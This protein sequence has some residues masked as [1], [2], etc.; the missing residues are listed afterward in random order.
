MMSMKNLKTDMD[1]TYLYI[2]D[3]DI[4]SKKL[5]QQIYSILSI[6]G[7]EADLK[8]LMDAFSTA[9]DNLNVDTSESIASWISNDDNLGKFMDC[10]TIKNSLPKLSLSCLVSNHS[11]AMMIGYVNAISDNLNINDPDIARIIESIYPDFTK[12]CMPLLLKNKEIDV[13]EE[14]FLN[15]KN[16]LYN[17]QEPKG[18][19]SLLKSF[20]PIQS[21]RNNIKDLCGKLF[22]DLSIFDYIQY[23]NIFEKLNGD[24]LI[25][26]IYA[27]SHS[28]LSLRKSGTIKSKVQ[29][30][31]SI[32]DEDKSIQIFDT[33]Q[34]SLLFAKLIAI[35]DYVWNR[36]ST[37]VSS[38]TLNE[39]E[40]YL[41]MSL[42]MLF[43][44][45]YSSWILSN[46]EYKRLYAI[47][48]ELR[49]K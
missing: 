11:F 18:M 34:T 35:N 12:K 27:S 8:Q 37:E 25:S 24:C 28:S 47:F 49:N 22:P 6:C 29:K 45:N 40:K 33:E 21:Q 32:I 2:A 19:N 10:L 5:S 26:D 15:L 39:N 38:N 16:C 48:E 4:L 42:W 46:M 36:L 7:S 13:T 41:I 43:I 44:G 1:K 31:K 23:L 14:L 17:C 9:L 30:S 20:L 3:S